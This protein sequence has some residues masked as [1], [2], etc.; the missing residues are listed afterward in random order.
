MAEPLDAYV[1]GALLE[2][3]SRPGVIEAMCNVIDTDDHDIAALQHEQA[4]IRKGLKTL[5][6]SCDAGDIDAEQLAIASRRKRQRDKEI[7][8]TLTAAQQ[9]SPLSVLLGADNIEAMWDNILTMGQKRAILAETLVVTV[10]P[11]NSG[12]RVPGGGYFNRDAIDIQLTDRAR[13]VGQLQ[14]VSG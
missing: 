3:L 11:T 5:A 1:E 6:A 9:R 8:A 4:E 2:L 7:T 13:G 10:L 14:Q 12:G